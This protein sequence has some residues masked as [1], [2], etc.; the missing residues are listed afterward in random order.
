MNVL[1]YVYVIEALDDRGRRFFYVGSSAKTPEERFQE[2]KNG[3]RYCKG[4]CR[5][6]K[7]HVHGTKL[8]LCRELFSQYNPIRTRSEAE[9]IENWLARHIRKRGYRVVSR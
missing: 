1:Y 7:K 6:G 9:E 8:R 3:K 4:E 2:H 5:G